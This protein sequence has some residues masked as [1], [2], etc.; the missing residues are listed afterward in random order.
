MR[1]RDQRILLVHPETKPEKTW[2]PDRF[3]WVLDRFLAARPEY[4]V[5]VSSLAPVDFG[6]GDPRVIRIDFHLELAFALV[7]HVDLFL[8][9][10]SCF[11][12]A[13]DLFR[14][15]GIGLFG[16]TRPS[17]WGFRLSPDA[18]HI[19]E[20]SMADVRR[21]P[22]LEALLDIAGA[23]ARRPSSYPPAS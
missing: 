15:S 3:A 18:R 8:G 5:L 16:P 6:V 20:A 10:D 1:Q 14:V 9:V 19:A 21:E 22:V 4:V 7:R 23:L 11:L 2:P 17:Q 12:H 13:A